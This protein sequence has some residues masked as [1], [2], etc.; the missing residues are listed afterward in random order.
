MKLWPEGLTVDLGGITD[1][2]IDFKELGVGEIKYTVYKI[3]FIYTW[4]MC[5][6]YRGSWL[7]MSTGRCGLRL[8]VTCLGMEL[9]V[10]FIFKQIDYYLFVLRVMKEKL[11]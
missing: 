5:K 6:I 4:L 7:Q 1:A 10:G 8:L 11:G 2:Q 9:L 3:M